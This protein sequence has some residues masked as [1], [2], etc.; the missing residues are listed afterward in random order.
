M[1]EKAL[2]FDINFQIYDN[3]RPGYP[4]EI[5][6]TISNYGKFS[7]I[8]NFLEI[9]AGN[10]I[11]SQE[12]YKKWAPK[13]TL[14]EP[15]NNLCDLLKSKFG[16][17]KNIEI[18]NTTFENYQSE[19]LYDAIFSATAFHWVDLSIKYKK[20]YE[21]LKNNGLLILYWNNYGIE[22]VKVAEE[23]QKI[24]IKYG[25][26]INNPKSIYE[27]QLEKI[28]DRKKEIQNSGYFKIL[29]HKIVKHDK[30]YKS[31]DYIHLLK[32]FSDHEKMEERFFE[33]I[34]TIIQ[35]NENRIDV[36]II[37]NLEIAVKI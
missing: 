35:N 27:T 23:I 13:L 4:N 36:R 3:V 8:S 2:H 20:S 15:G 34:M 28:E 25:R 17:I 18:H 19:I 26:G 33:E 1:E 37:T 11:A 21:M 6:E 10:G 12:I 16:N 14:I 7:K 31:N 32:T 5:Y 29:E 22:N 30:E 9:G 24:Y